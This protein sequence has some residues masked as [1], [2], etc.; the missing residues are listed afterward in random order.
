MI[1]MTVDVFVEVEA[2]DKGIVAVWSCD[3]LVLCMDD[4]DSCVA[5]THCA[6]NHRHIDSRVADTVLLYIC[7]DN[8][9]SSCCLLALQSGIVVCL[10]R[11]ASFC[12]V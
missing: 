2:Q 12:L 11:L 1:P 5:H 6:S 4:G 7:H 3:A 8:P 10:L 9:I